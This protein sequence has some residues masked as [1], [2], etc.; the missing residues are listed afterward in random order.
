[1]GLN[2]TKQQLKRTKAECLQILGQNIDED[3]LNF[4]ADLSAKK[5]INDKLRK[6]KMMIKTVI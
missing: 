4:L 6:N 5:G 1:M 2:L 3:N